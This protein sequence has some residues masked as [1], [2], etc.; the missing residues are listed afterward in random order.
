[1]PW[2]QRL[3]RQGAER[4]ETQPA[5]LFRWKPR[6]GCATIS[7][8]GPRKRPS[9]PEVFS[10]TTWHHPGPPE[11]GEDSRHPGR[12][13]GPG[14]PGTPQT[15]LR[16]PRGPAPLDSLPTSTLR[17]RFCRRR[18][19]PR[20]RPPQAP[21]GRAAPGPPQ[22]PTCEAAAGA[23]RPGPASPGGVPRPYGDAGWSSPSLP[24]GFSVPPRCPI[25]A[26]YG[27]APPFPL[28]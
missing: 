27:N 18:P 21:P 4:A 28:G 12:R 23:A 25:A 24:I 1:M 17:R 19:R 9:R 2:L 20:P 16:R 8:R 26:D 13:A 11:R 15:G 14:P 6:L 10:R 5:R 7:P 22:G 3:L